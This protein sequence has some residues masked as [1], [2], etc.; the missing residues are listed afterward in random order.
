VLTNK[1]LLRYTT[2]P[3][4]YRLYLQ[5]RF[6]LNKCIG[7]EFEKAE[8]YFRQAIAKDRNFALGYV[9]VAEFLGERDRPKAKEYDPA[10]DPLRGDPR[11]QEL[12][13]KFNP[14]Q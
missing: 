2:D 4:A 3:E 5:G 8:S 13:K 1:N 7:K 6:Y 12:L 9:G 10:F 11:F 14:P